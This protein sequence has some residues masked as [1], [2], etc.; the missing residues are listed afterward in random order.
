M[1]AAFLS[2]YRIPDSDE[3]SI[4]EVFGMIRWHLDSQS[5]PHN[6]RNGVK[7]Q[8]DPLIQSTLHLIDLGQ[9]TGSGPDT[10]TLTLGKLT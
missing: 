9:Y 5:I 3:E 4:S 10:Y 8:S 7:S 6:I 1:L 2:L